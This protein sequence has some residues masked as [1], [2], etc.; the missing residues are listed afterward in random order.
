M[1]PVNVHP[2]PVAWRRFDADRCAIGRTEYALPNGSS[3]SLYSAE[4]T[5][6]DLFRLRHLWGSDLTLGA[7]KWWLRGCGSRFGSL[8]ALAEGF[9][10]AR[11]AIQHT[12]ESVL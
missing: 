7:L 11:L 8:L 12:L 10:K 2:A 5:L 4:R 6:I 1:Q 3:I 9:P